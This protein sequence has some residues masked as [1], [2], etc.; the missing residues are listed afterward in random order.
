[1]RHEGYWKDP[2]RT[3]QV[4]D[5]EGW[6]YTGDMMKMDEDRH[7]YFVER[8]SEVINVAGEKVW[9]AEVEEAILQHLGGGAHCSDRGF[10]I[11]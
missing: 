2:E 1:M 4:I 3:K 7:L 9:P 10:Q 5:E 11:G 8:K 6:L